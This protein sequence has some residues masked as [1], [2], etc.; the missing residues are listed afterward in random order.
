MGSVSFAVMQHPV[1][2]ALQVLLWHLWIKFHC[3]CMIHYLC[4]TGGETWTE[5]DEAVCCRSHSNSQLCCFPALS[6]R[7]GCP[8]FPKGTEKRFISPLFFFF[9]FSPASCSCVQAE[10]NC[11]DWWSKLAQTSCQINFPCLCGRGAVWQES[12]GAKGT[13]WW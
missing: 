8:F 7:Q 5:T 6:Q 11:L 4:Y 3:P 13:V 2:K 1:S 9:F 12:V 10:W